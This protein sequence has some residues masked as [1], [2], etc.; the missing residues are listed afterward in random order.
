MVVVT[1]ATGHIGNNLVRRLID[2]GEEVRVLIHPGSTEIPLEGLNVEK[3]YG[4]VLVK[5]DLRKLF[6]GAA[7]VYHLAAIVS[8]LPGQSKGLEDVNIVGAK[9]V[10]EVCLEQKIAKLLYVSSVHAIGAV[11]DGETIT[12]EHPIRV[13]TAIG[14]YGQTK[15]AAT[16][17]LL[18]M[19]KKQGLNIIIVQPSG[20]IGP[21]DYL[22]SQLG[23]VFSLFAKGLNMGVKGGYDFVDVRDLVNGIILAA[24]KGQMGERYILSGNFISI[25]TKKRTVNQ[26][27]N[28]KSTF[29][30][31]P[32]F[33]CHLGAD[34][35]SPFY[36]PLNLIPVLTRESLEILYSNGVHSNDKAKNELGYS[37]RPYS[38][39]V[40][41]IVHW[42]KD[43]SKIWKVTK[44]KI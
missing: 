9:N 8:I 2:Q 40:T 27:L 39:T 23:L 31:M 11:P 16:L 17:A 34:I 28:K 15:A 25:E 5:D 3:V 33:L 35:F 21:H 30:A 41:D 42:I 44:H 43:N 1:G 22:P 26:V 14:K 29:I 18:E 6:K 37:V 7:I 32:K 36:K 19:H 12:E 20:V 24:E 13:D 10:G 4:D 38:E